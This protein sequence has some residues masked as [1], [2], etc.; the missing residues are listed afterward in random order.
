MEEG[1][2]QPG[3]RRQ[4]NRVVHC[5]P[6]AQ[7]FYTSAVPP[8]HLSLT[9]ERTLVR[10]RWG[11]LLTPQKQVA[12]P[13]RLKVTTNLPSCWAFSDSGVYAP[14]PPGVGPSTSTSV[15]A[16]LLCVGTLILT[17]FS[18]PMSL[19]KRQRIAKKN[20]Q[21]HRNDS[22]FTFNNVG[23]IIRRRFRIR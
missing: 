9:E 11:G 18:A 13:A 21:A 16:Q 6:I 5:H 4:M 22:K 23:R 19:A 12:N 10:L 2:E 8:I 3:C 17:S 15:C 7:H 20:K 1:I 14:T